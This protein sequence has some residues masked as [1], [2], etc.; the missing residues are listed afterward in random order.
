[1]LTDF[2]FTHI[3]KSFNT[4]SWMMKVKL[5]K[6]ELIMKLYLRV[7]EYHLPYRIMLYINAKKTVG[8]NRKDV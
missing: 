3:S 8:I 5:R 6:V 7:M 2:T 1:M 4:V